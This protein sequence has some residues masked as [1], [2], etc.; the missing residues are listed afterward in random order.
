VVALALTRLDAV[1]DLGLAPALCRRLADC[2][3]NG[4]ELAVKSLPSRRRRPPVLDGNGES[5]RQWRT[6]AILRNRDRTD[7]D[8]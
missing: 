4:S 6:G 5:N 2:S 3:V 1:A 8:A 7:G